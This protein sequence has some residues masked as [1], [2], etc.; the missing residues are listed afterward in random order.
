MNLL[1]DLM[2]GKTIAEKILG[3]HS[4]SGEDVKPDE[5]IFADIDLIM[6]HFGTAKLILDFHSCKV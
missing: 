4:I 2:S 6:S 3:S 5:I 1:G